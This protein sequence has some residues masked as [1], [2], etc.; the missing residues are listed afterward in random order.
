[1]LNVPFLKRPV[2]SSHRRSAVGA[3]QGVVFVCVL[4]IQMSSHL[5]CNA[6]SRILGFIKL[7]VLNWLSIVRVKRIHRHNAWSFF[8]RN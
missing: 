5:L 8:A 1:M 4:V 2:G 7:I 3:Y 6:V